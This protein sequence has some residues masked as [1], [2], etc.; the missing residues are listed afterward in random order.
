MKITAKDLEAA[1][2]ASIPEPEH[3]ILY[4]LEEMDD[5]DRG[6]V[7]KTAALLTERFIAPLEALIRDMT[8]LL[9]TETVFGFDEHMRETQRCLTLAKELTGEEVKE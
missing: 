7:E 9:D 5:G 2:L 8:K 3:E 1:V 4:T 6:Q